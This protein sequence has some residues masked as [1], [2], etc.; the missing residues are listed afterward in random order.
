[1]KIRRLT[2]EELADMRF[3]EFWKLQDHA[4]SLEWEIPDEDLGIAVRLLSEGNCNFEDIVSLDAYPAMLY[5]EPDIWI[6]L[7]AMNERYAVIG[8]CHLS[9]VWQVS[10]ENGDELRK[11]CYRVCGKLKLIL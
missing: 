10:V 1:M 8:G 3:T 5:D 6:D 9:T 4:N 2:E 11:K 7:K